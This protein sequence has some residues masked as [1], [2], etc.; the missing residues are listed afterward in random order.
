MAN[1]ANEPNDPDDAVTLYDTGGFGLD[2]DDLSP[3][4]PTFQIRVRSLSYVN[5]YEKQRVI[6]DLI[7]PR[8]VEIVATVPGRPAFRTTLH[9]TAGATVAVDV[10]ALAAPAEPP[11][12]GPP[13][14]RRSFVALAGGHT[15]RLTRSGDSE[16]RDNALSV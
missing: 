16:R 6:R 4:L 14:R 8:D 3:S 2:T 12:P 7:E 10:P 15:G 5:A 9:A 13:R 11:A 1:V